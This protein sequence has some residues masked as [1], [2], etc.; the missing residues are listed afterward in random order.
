MSDL[1]VPKYQYHVLT[2]G[3]F[4]NDEYKK[5]HGLS[6]GDFLFDTKEER[7]VFI[8]Q[9]KELEAY[10]DAR[11]CV[12]YKTEGYFC[13]VRTVLH[14]ITKFKGKEYYTYKDLGIN[15]PFDVAKYTL[16][17]KWYLGFN[18]YPLGDDFNY[19]THK[20]ETVEWITGA[21]L[22]GDVDE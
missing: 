2:W 8:N 16:E 13:N 21:I 15:Y 14:R 6:S 20:I 19:D 22:A 7:E 9:R 1:P 11:Y 10:L 5:I 12:F 18:D 4:Y 3:G 17:N